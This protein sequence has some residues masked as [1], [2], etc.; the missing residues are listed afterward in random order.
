MIE[1]TELE[2]DI[3]YIKF[4]N[5]RIGS[6]VSLLWEL[7]LPTQLVIKEYVYLFAYEAECSGRVEWSEQQEVD[8]VSL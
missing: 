3:R 2:V 1:Y 8:I 6:W 7:F 5:I 4:K